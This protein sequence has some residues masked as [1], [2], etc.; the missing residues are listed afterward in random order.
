MAMRFVRP[1]RMRSEQG[2]EPYQWDKVQ[3]REKRARPRTTF[4]MNRNLEASSEWL[5]SNKFPRP[6]VK[7]DTEIKAMKLRGINACLLFNRTRIPRPR[8]IAP[9]IV[10]D[11]SSILEPE[12]SLLAVWF[13]SYLPSGLGGWNG[14]ESRA[15]PGLSKEGQSRP[16][17]SIYPAA[18]AWLWESNREARRHAR[19]Y[20]NRTLSRKIRAMMSR[21]P[22]L[23]L[24]VFGKNSHVER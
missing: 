14:N 3:L 13:N 8:Q 6:M 9:P 16:R 19:T 21:E 15:L 2:F 5:G 18:N 11:Q 7:L 22:G 24:T 23:D 1:S 20:R 10:S 17:I 12:A 4:A